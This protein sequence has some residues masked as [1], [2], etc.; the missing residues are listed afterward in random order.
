M[1][2]ETRAQ[3]RGLGGPSWPLGLFQMDPR[4]PLSSLLSLTAIL[5]IQVWD[6]PTV[7]GLGGSWGSPESSSMF[8]SLA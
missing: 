1:M 3:S 8:L 2:Q 5:H 4:G 6:F 7:R